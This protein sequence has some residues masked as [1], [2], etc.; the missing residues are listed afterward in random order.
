MK[1]FLSSLPMILTLATIAAL[2][3]MYVLVDDP[4]EKKKLLEDAAVD[5]ESHASAFS[6]AR[7]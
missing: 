1:R 3:L 6:T 7:S 5:V 2:G 4:A